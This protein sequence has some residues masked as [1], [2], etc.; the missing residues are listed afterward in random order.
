MFIFDF[1]GQADCNFMI[2]ASVSVFIIFLI[3]ARLRN[4]AAGASCH[5]RLNKAN[6]FFLLAYIAAA[7]AYCCLKHIFNIQV[8]SAFAGGV[9]VFVTL[10][11]IYLMALI[12]LVKKSVSVTVVESAEMPEGIIEQE[13]KNKFSGNTDAVRLNRL[14]QM[15]FLGLATEEK[16]RFTI[17]GRGKFFNALGNAILKIWGLGRL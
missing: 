1:F 5:A 3:F 6:A 7:I 17:T 13:L 2:Y 16:N 8:L 9:F 14:E 11:Q 4:M 10:Q 15:K 12:G